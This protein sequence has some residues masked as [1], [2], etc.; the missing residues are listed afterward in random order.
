M[1]G[2]CYYTLYAQLKDNRSH[3][4]SYA[5]S[6]VSSFQTA[7]SRPHLIWPLRQKRQGG[8]A[9]LSPIVSVLT[10]KVFRQG[11][12]MI[13]GLC[14]RSWPGVLSMC[15]W[16]LCSHQYHVGVHGNWHVRR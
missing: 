16:G 15:G 8:M 13:H 4:R 1:S 11:L 7:T 9:F 14:W 2:I 12:D 5:C 3:T 6:M 10:P